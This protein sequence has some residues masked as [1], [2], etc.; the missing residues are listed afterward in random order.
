MCCP[1]G[2]RPMNNWH[3]S[4]KNTLSG[5]KV[6]W[7]DSWT[8]QG[9]S[10]SLQAADATAGEEEHE[11]R[12]GGPWAKDG[13]DGCPGLDLANTRLSAGPLRC[14]AS[15]R[16][17]FRDCSSSLRLLFAAHL[18][19]LSRHLCP[20]P[21]SYIRALIDRCRYFVSRSIS[22]LINHTTLRPSASCATDF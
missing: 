11:E 20:F 9:P 7:L 8:G 18:L 16:R 15:S 10:A 22:D 17:W 5:I 3:C 1:S 12:G 6:S 4:A 19:L 2:A 21:F 14:A 13:S